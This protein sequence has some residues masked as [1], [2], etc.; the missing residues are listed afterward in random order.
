MSVRTHGAWSSSITARSLAEGGL[1]LSQPRLDR[2]ALFWIEGRPR[3]GGRQVVMRADPTGPVCITPE[4]INVRS[5]VYEYGGGDYAVRDGLL[6]FASYADSRLYRQPTSGGAATALTNG[7][8]LH[9]DLHIAPDGRWLVAVQERAH[10]G[11]EPENRLV[12][13]RLDRDAAPRV[14]AE[15][16]DFYSSPRFSPD[17]RELAFLAWDHPNMPWDGTE[18]VCVAWTDDGPGRSRVVAGGSEESIFQPEFSPRGRLT[19]VSDR[20]GWWNLE[21]LR[22]SERVRLCPTSA[23]FGRP[24]WALGTT[25]Y[26]FLDEERILCVVSEGGFHR[27]ARLDVASG[28]LESVETGMTAFDGVCA[29]GTRVG[30]IAAGPDRAPSVGTFDATT[31]AFTPV[32]SSLATEPAAEQVSRP[33]AIAFPTQSGETAHAFLYRPVN[34]AVRAPAGESPPLLVKAHGGPTGAAVAA[35]DLRIQYW[36]SR[37]FCVLDVNYRGSTGFGRA[38]RARLDGAWGVVDV[39]DCVHAARDTARRGLADPERLAISGG[40]AGGY[41]VL[42]ALTF[43]EEFRAGASHYGIADLEALARDTHKFESRYLDR[44]VGPYPRRRDLYV[45]RSPLHHADR[46][47]CPVIFFQGLEDRVVPPSQAETMVAALAARGI[48]H[49]Y[50]P[51]EG[52]QHGFRRAESVR[53]ALEGELFFYARVFGFEVDVQPPVHIIGL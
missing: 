8:A 10:P 14:V 31:G 45:A 4:G 17:G 6:C 40:S 34:P 2:G 15:G 5:R 43:W 23:E 52:E 9:A 27:L 53:T 49:A 50:V 26:A 3:E 1:R 51:F 32:R 20:S 7:D 37:G 28:R 29:E 48:P 16:R 25:T 36:T 13:L 41:T 47:S 33:E 12:A 11:A 30:L 22:G 44:L 35:L 42:C 39:A 46:L 21:Q 38:Y 19:F 18:L 24:Q